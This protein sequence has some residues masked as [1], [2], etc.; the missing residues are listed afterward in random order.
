MVSANS[1]I[2]SAV[3]AEH[4]RDLQRPGDRDAS[5]PRRARREPRP[6]AVTLV[7]RPRNATA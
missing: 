1:T 4:I 2:M 5:C 7:P 6:A 3:A